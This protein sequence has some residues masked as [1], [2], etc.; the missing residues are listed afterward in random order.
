[1]DYSELRERVKP[2]LEECRNGDYEHTLR[3]VSLMKL[4]LKT[5]KGN[6]EILMPAAYLHEIGYYKLIP[7]SERDNLKIKEMTKKYKEEHML[8]GAKLAEQI[9]TEL[10]Y[11]EIQ[12]NQIVHLVSIHDK[13]DSITEHDEF[14]IADA[15]NLSKLDVNHI[16]EKYSRDDWHN[17]LDVFKNKLPKRLRTKTAK[18]LFKDKLLKLERDLIL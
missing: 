18:K 14:M 9:L 11:P 4:L 12:K 3:V 7:K 6:S 2:Y 1:M 13:W 16:K 8:L 10:N 5:E 17:V 15:D